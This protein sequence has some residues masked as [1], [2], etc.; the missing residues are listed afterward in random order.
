MDQQ[1]RRP[2]RAEIAVGA[3][4]CDVREVALVFVPRAMGP[5]LPA[6]AGQKMPLLRRARQMRLPNLQLVSTRLSLKRQRNRQ[7]QLLKS[8]PQP[9][10]LPQLRHRR[11][12]QKLPKK[13]GKRTSRHP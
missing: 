2:G 7:N 8:Q 1:Q 9:K 10:K 11:L 4:T 3:L 5:V 6:L 12:P 13:P